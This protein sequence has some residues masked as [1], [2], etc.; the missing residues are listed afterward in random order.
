[1][2]ARIID[3]SKRGDRPIADQPKFRWEAELEEIRP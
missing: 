1:M 3:G 2:S